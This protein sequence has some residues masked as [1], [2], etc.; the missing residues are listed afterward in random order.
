MP[1][2]TDVAEL[3]TDAYFSEPAFGVKSTTSM[4]LSNDLS[5]KGPIC[6]GFRCVDEPCEQTCANAFSLC[7]FANIDADLSDTGRPS[8]TVCSG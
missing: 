1:D 8:G 2:I 4:V 6:R 7:G 5:S 3:L